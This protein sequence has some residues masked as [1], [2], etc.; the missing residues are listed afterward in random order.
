MPNT[1]FHPGSTFYKGGQWG[2]RGASSRKA[3]PGLP[4][5]ASVQPDSRRGVCQPRHARPSGCSAQRDTERP[6]IAEY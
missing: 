6:D 3:G 4:F 5:T 2:A 1:D